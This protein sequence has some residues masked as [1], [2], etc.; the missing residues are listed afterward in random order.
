MH[1][2]LEPCPLTSIKNLSIISDTPPS[3]YRSL[4]LQFFHPDRKESFYEL[5]ISKEQFRALGNQIVIPSLLL[6]TALP[7][8]TYYLCIKA[9]SEENNILSKS[10]FIT[11]N[12]TKHA[13]SLKEVT[14]Q[15]PQ[16]ARIL[17]YG[18]FESRTSDIASFQLYQKVSN[19]Y[20][21][22]K[23]FQQNNLQKRVMNSLLQIFF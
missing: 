13:I 2:K 14:L 21:F 3:I 15:K 20:F 16:Y 11:C 5:T 1:I 12:I 6:P 18:N 22:F 9:L 19:H 17:A 10:N 7:D 23:T 8:G 4:S